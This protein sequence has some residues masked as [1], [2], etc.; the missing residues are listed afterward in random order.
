M[1][2]HLQARTLHHQG[3]LD[4][5]SFGSG[6]VAVQRAIE[7]LGY[8]Q[9]DTLAVVE[10]AHHHT[11]WSRI[12]GYHP[13][14]LKRAVQARTVFEY[15][16]H[17][18]SYLP[19]RDYRFALLQ[20][21]EARQGTL[22]Y[23]PKSEPR[24]LSYVLDRIRSEGPLKARDF[25]APTR[26][27]SSWWDWKPAKKALERLFFQGD[28]MI[29]H[30]E[31]MEK[32]YDLTERVLPSHVDTRLPSVMDFAAYLIHQSVTAHGFTTL[33][34]VSHLRK[35]AALRKALKETM[36]HKTEAG[37]LIEEK[38]LGSGTVYRAANEGTTTI[39]VPRDVLRILSPFDNAIIHRDRLKVL[40]DF[41]YKLECYVPQSKRTY[42]YFCLPILYQNRFVGRMDC[43]AHRKEGL[44]E[45]ITLFI[46]KDICN[47]DAF[48]S[49][50]TAALV[51]FAEFNGCT[52]VMLTASI[53][54]EW[55]GLGMSL[56]RL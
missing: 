36:Q 20:M 8:V 30:R 1:K 21:A 44:F 14:D 6:P 4:R 5:E 27:A 43:K 49:L 22:A 41:D 33:K 17:A 47:R 13:D 51:D 2:E 35:G 50:L 16:S 28:L 45:V 52:K 53:P 40:F 3:L 54:D 46:E 9:I 29:A 32:V 42:G 19:M 12:K 15:W 55:S 31:G 10:R 24:Y 48:L 11:L 56:S 37:E 25:E 18:A 23:C 34:Q 7:K 38:T 39:E 26:A